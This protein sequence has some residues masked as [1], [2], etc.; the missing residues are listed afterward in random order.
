[1]F[2]LDPPPGFQGL[3]PDLPIKIYQHNLPHWRQ[4]GATY[5]TTFRL[6]DALPAEKRAELQRIKKNW[7]A[8][9]PPPHSSEKAS[10]L[11]SLIGKQ[12]EAFLDAGYGSCLLRET[13]DRKIMA[14]ALKFFDSEF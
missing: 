2:H 3:Q 4:N 5:F 11:N 1:M 12:S 13:A 10:A 8:E 14:N 9:N 7:E 6:N